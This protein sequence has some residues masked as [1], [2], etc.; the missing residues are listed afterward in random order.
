MY[1]FISTMTADR[2]VGLEPSLIVEACDH[3]TLT[4]TLFICRLPLYHTG[5]LS[6]IYIL[7]CVL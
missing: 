5:L 6:D 1:V 3:N 2:E 4:L 7:Q